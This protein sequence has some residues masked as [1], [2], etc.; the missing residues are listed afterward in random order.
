MAH[1]VFAAHTREAYDSPETP[2]R[3][4]RYSDIGGL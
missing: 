1:G 2:I 4:V 3:R